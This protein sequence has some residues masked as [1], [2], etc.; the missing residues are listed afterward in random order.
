[1]HPKT[2]V[3]CAIGIASVRTARNIEA[4]CIVTPTMSGK[5]ARMISSFRPTMPIYAITPNER[6]QRK[7]RLYWGVRPLK[8][9]T[10]DTTENIIINAMETLKENKLVK[11]GQLVVVTA[12]DPATNSSKAEANVTNMLHVMEV[13]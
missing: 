13:K 6:V 8:G 5:T 3:S 7:M 9:Y 2:K 4:D 12:G 1:M 10:R 11:K